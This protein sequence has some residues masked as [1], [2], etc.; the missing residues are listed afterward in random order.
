MVG[1]LN[2]PGGNLAGVTFL[3]NVTTGK[4]LE[5]LHELV[6]T[7]SIAYVTNV[8]DPG[9]E[10]SEFEVAARALGVRSHIVDVR[11]KSEF[12]ATFLA[13]AGERVGAG[14]VGASAVLT[15]NTAELVALAAHYRLP[16]MYSLTEAVAAGGL[17]SYSTDFR[18]PLRVV[19]VYTGRILKGE[20][21]ADLPVQQGT[22][23][24]LSI[25]LKTAK[26]LGV[27]VPASLLAIADE[28]IE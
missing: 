19:G 23:L 6:P 8:V 26:A 16:A 11:D 27:I 28:V 10:V 25:N 9:S 12:E 4:R 18:D 20:K 22:K 17:M 2:R 15:G 7:A 24:Q 13:L 5:L 3:G 21:P 1:S 14:V